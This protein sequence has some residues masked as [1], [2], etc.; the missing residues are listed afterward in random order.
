MGKVDAFEELLQK[1]IDATRCPHC[2]M[3]NPAIR[4]VP[5]YRSGCGTVMIYS[6][7]SCKHII[8]V[9]FVQDEAK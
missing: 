4:S 5:A 3:A 9:G 7:A 6:C 8:S 1:S 2:N